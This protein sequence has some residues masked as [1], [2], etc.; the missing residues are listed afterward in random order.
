MPHV[1]IGPALRRALI[2]T[3]GA[4]PFDQAA[5]HRLWTRTEAAGT[6]GQRGVLSKPTMD[7]LNRAKALDD[8]GPS[9]T[10]GER[11]EA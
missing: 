4:D 5:L 3:A 6:A 9:L 8:R 2:R 1:P 10:E 7:V 11:V